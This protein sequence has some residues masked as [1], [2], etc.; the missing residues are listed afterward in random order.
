MNSF[1]PDN[2]NEGDWE[3]K[4][5]LVWSEANWNQY[6]TNCML[7]V[8]K[9]LTFYE[10]SSR[11]P[12]HLDEIARHMGWEVSDWSNKDGYP[13]EDLPEFPSMEEEDFEPSEPY[14]LH[15]HPVYIVTQGLF[16][17]LRK[18]FNDYLEN[19]GGPPVT[20][21]LSWNYASA[22]QESEQQAIMGIQALDMADY[23][24][25]ICHFKRALS[26]INQTMGTLGKVFPENMEVPYRKEIQT[27]LFDLREVYLRIIG[28]CRYFESGDFNEPF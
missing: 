24:L 14:T 13:E 3:D 22:L 20:A 15:R 25:A 19:S 12:G 17:W 6:L 5:E 8:S 11:G 1:N 21:R 28:E 4:G 16:F 2:S 10:H 23:S 18:S 26:G 27:R 9:F 7:E